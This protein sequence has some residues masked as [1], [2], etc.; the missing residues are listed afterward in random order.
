MNNCNQCVS[1]F[2][3]QRILWIHDI[4]STPSSGKSVNKRYCEQCSLRISPAYPNL[5]K[6]I[7]NCSRIWNINQI[8]TFMSR[9]LDLLN[10]NSIGN[11]FDSWIVHLILGWKYNA[12][13]PKNHIGTSMSSAFDR[14]PFDPTFNRENRRSMSSQY[15]W[16][17]RSRPHW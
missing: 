2:L 15:V 12:L 4:T 1:L 6:G 14:W 17:G 13:Q 3:I 10:P 8:A 5:P 9:E 11:I 7:V 16:Y